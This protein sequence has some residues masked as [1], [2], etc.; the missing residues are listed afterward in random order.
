MP[1]TRTVTGVG[2]ETGVDVRD[3]GPE[4][5]GSSPYTRLLLLT[6]GVRTVGKSWEA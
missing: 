4:E 6:Y 5:V 3:V 2:S 1:E